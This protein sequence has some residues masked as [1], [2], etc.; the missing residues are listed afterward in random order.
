MPFEMGYTDS[1]G[2]NHPESYWVIKFLSANDPNKTGN[3]IFFG[4]HDSASYDAELGSIGEHRYDITD[5]A[6]YDFSFGYG[7][8]PQ[9]EAFFQIMEDRALDLDDF[10]GP[11]DVLSFVKVQS[12]EVGSDGPSKVVVTFFAEVQGSTLTDGVT[13]KINGVA[14]TI[15]SAAKSPINVLTYTIAEVVGPADV[16]TWEYL[17]SAGA[18]EDASSFRLQSFT[19]VTADNAVGSYLRFDDANNSIH[20]AHIF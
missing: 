15:V 5:P 1:M 19:P 20:L 3:I 18:L 16:V 8:Y 17:R 11:A 4:Y 2:V 10:F 9:P 13:I 6:F 12:A 14:A 7:R